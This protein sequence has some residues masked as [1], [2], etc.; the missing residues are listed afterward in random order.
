MLIERPRLAGQ[1]AGVLASFRAVELVGPR[2]VG[3]TTLARRFIDV[4]SPHSLDL[5]DPVSRQRLADPMS[6]LSDMQGL[7]VIDEIQ[8]L[9]ALP[10]TLRVLMDR[11][12]RMHQSGQHLLLGS[13]SP[14]VMHKSESLLGR[15]ATLEVSGFDISE[16]GGGAQAMQQLW[17]R[18]GYPPNA[19]EKEKATLLRALAAIGHSASG[20]IPEGM[21][22]DFHDVAPGD[23]KAFALMIDWCEKNQS[24]VILGG[25]LTSGAD[26]QASTNALGNVHNEVRKDL[27]DGDVRQANTTLT[28][29]LV[30]AVASLNGLA[31]GGLRRAPRFR[32][33]AQ[34]REDLTAFAQGLPPLVNLGLRP[35]VAWAHERLGI[36]VAQDGE[37]VLLPQPDQ[38][39]APPPAA[40]AA[41]TA[42]LAAPGVPPP[43]VQMQPRLAGDLAPAVGAWIDQVRDLVMRAQS[44]AEIRDGLDALLPGMTLDQYAAAM[45]EALR[46][47][48]GAGRYEVMQEAAGGLG[49]GSA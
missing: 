47:A 29:D 40:V 23:P 4:G 45:A 37:P 6:T 48:E 33:K 13:A 39:A 36:P 42:R 18:R 10:E 38:R 16:A 49:V 27:R 9:S 28:R 46:A 15:A 34:E 21:L 31:P 32:L 26:G 1:L 20:I 24:K 8:R 3:K 35:P 7:V 41:A 12:D 44:L 30:F 17:L 43:P 11:P 14:R 22:I 5:E 2:Q 19:S 25:T